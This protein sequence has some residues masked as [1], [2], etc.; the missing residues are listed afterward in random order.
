LFTIYEK[1]LAAVYITTDWIFLL[2]TGRCRWRE[3]Y[4]RRS[5]QKISYQQKPEQLNLP[6]QQKL[7]EGRSLF[8]AHGAKGAVFVQPFARREYLHSMQKDTR[9]WHIPKNALRVTGVIPIAQIW[10]LLSTG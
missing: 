9:W 2:N 5:Y 8:L 1:I 7:P 6:R 10:P 3:I 4:R